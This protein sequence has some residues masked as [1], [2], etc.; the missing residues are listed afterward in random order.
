MNQTPLIGRV[1]SA[2]YVCASA[3][4]RRHDVSQRIDIV[5]HRPGLRI[6]RTRT[7]DPSQ[8]LENDERAAL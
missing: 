7:F 3:R 2:G 8:S 1:A 6:F 5:E 4:L